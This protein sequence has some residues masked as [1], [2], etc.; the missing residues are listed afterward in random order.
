D[1][2]AF[3]D[4]AQHAFELGVGPRERHLSLLAFGN[5]HHDSERARRLAS[6]VT[7]KHSAAFHPA[8]GPVGP[9]RPELGV[10]DSAI[11]HRL[12]EYR[13]GSLAILG[14]KPLRPRLVTGDDLTDLITQYPELLVVPD[15]F[16]CRQMQVPGRESAGRQGEV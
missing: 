13:F 6:R 12:R 14:V 3:G 5:V 15:D 4:A 7:V 1:Q 11:L 9:E 10:I 2:K 16:A 8:D